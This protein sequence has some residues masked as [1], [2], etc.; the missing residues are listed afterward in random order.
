MDL[1]KSPRVPSASTFQKHLQR[2]N[3]VHHTRFILLTERLLNNLI[4][5]PQHSAFSYYKAIL[6]DVF[7]ANQE[8]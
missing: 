4:T 6:C 2:N 5:C 7:S 8:G 3:C 1:L